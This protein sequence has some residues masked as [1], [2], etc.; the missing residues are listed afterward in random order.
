MEL[1]S[2]GTFGTLMVFFIIIIS[3]FST[4]VMFEPITY[5]NDRVFCGSAVTT[6]IPNVVLSKY[7]LVV[8]DFIISLLDFLLLIFNKRRIRAYK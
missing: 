5:K 3:I 2:S 8:A 4:F 7:V 1:K 6:L